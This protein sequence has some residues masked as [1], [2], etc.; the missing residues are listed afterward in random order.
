MPTK[1]RDLTVDHPGG[2]YVGLGEVGG[3][4]N[5]NYSNMISMFP[6][7]PIYSNSYLHE[8][9]LTEYDLAVHGPDSTD[10]K[11]ST[12]DFADV[13]MRYR[14]APDLNINVNLVSQDD[15]LLSHPYAPV[16]VV[17]GEGEEVTDAD[18]DVTR[19]A[20]ASAGSAPFTS[21]PGGTNPAQTSVR[22]SGYRLTIGSLSFSEGPH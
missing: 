1:R 11:V 6:A 7:S 3:L 16:L 10:G 8:D 14:D 9:I 21:P 17:K 19:R 13:N 5:A 20:T 15:V 2:D 12:V 22:Q 4:S 18:I